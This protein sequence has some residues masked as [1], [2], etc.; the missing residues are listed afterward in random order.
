MNKPFTA[1]QLAEFITRIL[2]EDIG[3]GDVTTTATVPKG[4]A[5]SVTMNA[6]E[7]FVVAGIDITAAV[8]RRL[9]P[10]INIEILVR[11]GERVKK[12]TPLMTLKGKA[13]AI[14][15]GERAAL[16]ILQHLSGIATLSARYVKKL[17]GTGTILLDTR[18][19][20]PGLRKLEKYATTCGGAENHRMGLYD[21]ILIKDNHIA[22]AGGIRQAIRGAKALNAG[23][24]AGIPI[25]TECD[26][27][28][29]LK[30][31]L[32]EGIDLVLLDNMPLDQ[33]RKAVTIAKGKC[34]IEASGRVSLKTIRAIAETGVEYIST[35]KITQSAPSV[36]I[37]LDYSA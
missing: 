26:T 12:N 37:G 6:R 2:A 1:E 30:E 4:T 10:E 18:K 20:T 5:L 36:D 33:L 7:D 28:D 31:A 32:D 29:Q 8:F 17:D 9:D 16:N 14:L 21:A 27:L 11:D 23:I 35:S 34:K 15:T 22:A 3:S 13:R 25:E 19:T 24:P